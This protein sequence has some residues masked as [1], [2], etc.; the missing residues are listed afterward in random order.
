MSDKE[1]DEWATPEGLR[2][3]SK[4]NLALVLLE[5]VNRRAQS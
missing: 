5:N 4:D 3:L 1:L 2:E